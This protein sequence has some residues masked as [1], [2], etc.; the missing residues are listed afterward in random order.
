MLTGE[1]VA[2]AVNFYRV[3]FLYYDTPEY[4]V[5][6]TNRYDTAHCFIRGDADYHVH[7]RA[8]QQSEDRRTLHLVGESKCWRAPIGE[9]KEGMRYRLDGCGFFAREIT[10][11]YRMDDEQSEGNGPLVQLTTSS[12]AAGVPWAHVHFPPHWEITFTDGA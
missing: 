9:A 4:P 12:G 1:P 5:P 10:G 7:F 11:V 8:E 3:T 2:R 6:L